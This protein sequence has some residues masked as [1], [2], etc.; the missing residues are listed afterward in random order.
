[1]GIT[2]HNKA[3]AH[4]AVVSAVLTLCLSDCLSDD[5]VPQQPQPGMAD[6]YAKAL[7]A[8]GRAAVEILKNIDPGQLSEKLRSRR[9]CMLSR[10]EARELPDERAE[11][12][13]QAVLSRYQEYWLRALRHEHPADAN[14]TWLLT[15]LSP[16]VAEA[17]DQA[18]PSLDKLEPMLSAAISARG[19]HSLHGVTQPLR[20]FMLWQTQVPETYSVALPGGQQTV[21]VVFLDGFLSLGWAAF[22]TCGASYS[23]GWT[24]P[25][26][27]YAVRSAYDPTS[28]NFR[29]SYLAHEAQHFAD[30]QQFP[31]LE[32]PELEYR[33]KLAELALATTTAYDLL[34]AFA[35]NTA[36]D[37]RIPHSYANQRV[38]TD[39]RLR[40]IDDDSRSDWGSVGV[41]QINAAAKELLEYD[42]R[43]RL[44]Q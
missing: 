27:L 33:A 6:A 44:S 41:D 3:T 21:Q 43:A 34:A 2:K 36:K 32:Q 25:D 7:Q 9:A 39:M 19:F 35:T 5:R 31:G 38:V 8:D 11:P 28:E 14:E 17:A 4:A 13:I 12:F 20:E 23:G 10:L 29:V 37:R 40:L 18:P 24:R 16:L 30:N 15:S 42:S 1:M 26:A 22:A